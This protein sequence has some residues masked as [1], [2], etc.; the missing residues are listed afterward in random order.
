MKYVTVAE[1]VSIEKE[2]DSRGHSYSAMMEQAGLGLAKVVDLAY[3]HITEKKV[4]GLIGSGN[5]GGDALVAF[6]YLQEWGWQTTAYIAG[7]RDEDDVLIQ[8]GKDSGCEII[9]LR[10]DLSYE[11]LSSAMETHPILLDGLLG[12]GIRLPLR[13]TIKDVLGWVKLKITSMDFPPDI[14]AV[15][16]PSGVDC[17]SGEAAAECLRA[18]LTVTMAAYKEGILKFPAFNY[19]GELI[20]V[21]IGLPND[22]KSHEEITREV[23]NIDWVKGIL[24]VRPLD[25]HKSTFGVV[26]VM[27]G[28]VNYSGAVLLSG[29]AAFRSGA[30]WVTLAV[31][32]PLYAALAGSFMEA[33]WLPLPHKDGWFV[34]EAADELLQ[35][36]DRV[37]C[38]LI[39][40]GFG[41][42]T[43]TR[44]CLIQIIQNWKAEYPPVVIDADGLKL[45]AEIPDWY[46]QIPAP[47]ILTP[48][49]G[50]MSVLTGLTPGEIQVDRMGIAEEYAQRWGHV[51]VLKGA[52][53]VV[54]DPSGRSSLVPIATSALARAGTGDVLAGLIA[55]LRGQGMSA[56]D[57]A[58]SGAWIHATAGVNAGR[59]LGSTEVVLAGDVLEGVIDVFAM[60]RHN[61]KRHDS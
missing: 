4:L 12:T 55:G 56:F 40:P 49:P 36:I 50:E 53:T 9:P 44:K 32:E 2:A 47:A 51:V 21:G 25:S 22:L 35:N 30:G 28:S 29:K 57:A 52:F 19:V 13:G 42:Q 39:G 31:P 46:D 38:L 18:D 33:T 6:A 43:G 34:P 45:L 41:L 58:A 54:A 15:D 3:G 27:A 7:S 48:H 37:T 20:C 26:L 23:I 59:K 60:L 24:P 1:M 8:R 5:N 10:W 16:C 17:D 11:R 14:V 61:K